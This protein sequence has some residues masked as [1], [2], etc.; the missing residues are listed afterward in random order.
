MIFSEEKVE[1]I[2]NEV[3]PLLK[4]AHKESGLRDLELNPLKE[5]YISLQKSGLF[6]A[7]IARDD[8]GKLVGYSGF[9]IAAH[10]Q[11]ADKQ[12]AQQESFY[13]DKEH[14]GITAVKFFN[15]IEKRLEERGVNLIIRQSSAEADWSK[16]LIR[17]GYKEIETVYI[18]RLDHG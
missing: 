7:V 11:Y 15:Y 4:E 2:W 8:H 12:C 6:H 16:T 18:R 1:D 13:V 9:T 17:N 5:T 14:R 10:H 3:V